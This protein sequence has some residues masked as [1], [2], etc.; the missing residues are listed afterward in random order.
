MS[1]RFGKPP[2]GTTHTTA[3]PPPPRA[4]VAAGTQRFTD[5]HVSRAQIHTAHGGNEPLLSPAAGWLARLP[6]D[7]CVQGTGIAQ[8]ART[9]CVPASHSACTNWRQR[10]V[11]AAL[12]QPRVRTPWHWYQH[13]RFHSPQHPQ[14]RRLA[15]PRI[16]VRRGV[17]E[18]AATQAARRCCTPRCARQPSLLSPPCHCHCHYHCHHP[19]FSTTLMCWAGTAWAPTHQRACV[20][21]PVDRAPRWCHT[22]GARTWGLETAAWALRGARTSHHAAPRR[23]PASHTAG[24]ARTGGAGA[25]R[26]AHFSDHP[27]RWW[28]VFRHL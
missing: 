2:P 27:R 4:C 22:Q 12:P 17:A 6:A 10:V 9:S 8:Q 14:R 13:S 21:P 25:L 20:R 18:P 15:R 11:A 23:F 16:G 24:V 1:L 5:H 28:G 7:G 3:L 19:R 26:T